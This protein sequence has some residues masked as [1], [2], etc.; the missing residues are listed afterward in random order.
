MLRISGPTYRYSGETIHNEIIYIDDHCYD[1]QDQ[2]YHVEKLLTHNPGNHLLVFDNIKHDDVLC[3]WPHVCLPVHLAC[4][5]ENFQKQSITVNWQQKTHC[6]NFMINKPRLHRVRLLEFVE[7][8]G[9]RNRLHTLPWV[10]SDYPSIPVT[11]YRIGQ[12]QLLEK[13]VKNGSY[14][15]AETYQKLLQRQVFEPT[16]ISLITEPCYFE[17]ESLISEKT[18]MAI[19]AGTLPLWV[20]GW[21]LPDVMRDLG[22]DVFDDIL[23]HSYSALPDPQ[24]RVDQAL[25]RNQHLLENFDLVCDFL[26][27][28]HQRLRHNLDLL[29]QNIFLQQVQQ[30]VLMNPKLATVTSLWGLPCAN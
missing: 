12:E 1:E 10:H 7:S 17:R 11:D 14:S 15:N 23:D 24:Q 2:C 21:R 8:Q 16:C 20:G 22:F 3:V 4:E 25:I 6:F 5:I 13:G 28:N 29:R 19:Y 30:Q 18:V 9:L 26:H 27:R